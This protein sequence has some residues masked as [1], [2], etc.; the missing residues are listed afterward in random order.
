[1]SK[2]SHS[3][4]WQVLL[5]VGW[6]LSWGCQ[7]EHIYTAF[8]CDFDCLTAQL[9]QG[10]WSSFMAARGYKSACRRTQGK[11]CIAPYDVA[12]EVVKRHFPFI[13]TICKWDGNLC[14]CVKGWH[15]SHFQ[16]KEYTKFV[17][18]K[19]KTVTNGLLSNFQ[20]EASDFMNLID[21]MVKF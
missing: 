16:C 9:F 12:L 14:R 11:S 21:Y 18:I 10:S 19:K 6:D 7:L 1:M 17:D 5:V 15:R 8:L 4:G 20:L 2:V 13:V 3:P